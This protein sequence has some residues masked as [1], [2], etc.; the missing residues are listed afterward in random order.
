[1]AVLA[2]EILK[3]RYLLDQTVN[4]DTQFDD[5]YFLPNAL[6]Q[7]RRMFARILPEEMIP[8]LQTT[9]TIT[10]TAGFGAFP[11]DLLRHIADPYVIVVAAG[12]SIVASEI[13][14]GERWRLGFLE[15]NGLTAGSIPNEIAYY[16]KYKTGIQVWPNSATSVTFPYIKEPTALSSSDNTELPLDV[17]D[18]V[19]TYAFYRCMNTQRGDMDIAQQIL[20]EHQIVLKDA[21]V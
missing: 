19:V 5:T 15:G 1:M 14:Q 20:K 11:S 4:T 17:D 12:K 3:V 8:G 16:I 18:M 10:L 2:T 9:G 13:V 6:N 7:G 21:K